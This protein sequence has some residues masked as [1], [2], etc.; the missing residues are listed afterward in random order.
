MRWRRRVTTLWTARARWTLRLSQ[1]RTMRGP[2]CR[3][4]SRRK[5]KIHSAWTFSWGRRENS[6]RILRRRGETARA[7][8]TEAFW[9]ELP[10]C[11][12]TGVQPRSAQLRRTQGEVSSPDLV[13]EDEPG[14]PTG[15][16]FLPAAS[17]L[18]PSLGCAARHA[19]GPCESA[20][21]GVQPRERKT[22]PMWSTW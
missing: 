4:R 5:A 10:R 13:E 20:S 19:R 2:R 15:G 22:R 12:R 14:A 8:M 21:G 9:R 6:R 3:A 7:A 11:R 1:M 18:A 16:V 17:A